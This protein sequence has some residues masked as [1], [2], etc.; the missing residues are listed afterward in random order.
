MGHQT[1]EQVHALL[2][3]TDCFILPSSFDGWGAVVNEAL[4][5]GC[6][7]IV[8][9]NAGAHSLIKYTGFGQVFCSGDWK[10]FKKM[11]ESELVRGKVSNTQREKIKE[12]SKNIEPQTVTDYLVEIINFYFGDNKIKPQAPWNR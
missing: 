1:V 3:N 2:E 4:L 5:H 10:Q 11:A 12:Y 9:D 7:C 6:R 8:S